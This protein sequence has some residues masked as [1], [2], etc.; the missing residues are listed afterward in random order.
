MEQIRFEDE[1]AV[2]SYAELFRNK[3]IRKRV[4]LGMGIQTMQQ[5]R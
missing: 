1:K 2:K 4:I 3:S 5:V